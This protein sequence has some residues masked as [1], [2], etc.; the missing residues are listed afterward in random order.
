MVWW[1]RWMVWWERRMELAAGLDGVADG[2][3]AGL[4]GVA[5]GVAAGLDGVASLPSA[6]G[7]TLTT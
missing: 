4:D 5:D 6:D 3:A 7:S 2:V 1:E